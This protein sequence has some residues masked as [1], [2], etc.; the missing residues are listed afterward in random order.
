MHTT[1][2]GRTKIV[3]GPNMTVAE[4]LSSVD[5]FKH[6]SIEAKPIILFL[7][8]LMLKG[9]SNEIF[10]LQFFHLSNLLYCACAT[11]QGVK[12]FLVLVD[13]YYAEFF[14]N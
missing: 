3:H 7:A 2:Q 10:D 12:I 13:M 6:I 4:V 5:K 1:G 14:E 9:Q 11:D 8:Q